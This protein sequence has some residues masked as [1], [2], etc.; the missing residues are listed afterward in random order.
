MEVMKESNNAWKGK[1]CVCI[2]IY[3]YIYIYI[4]PYTKFVEI[5]I[6]P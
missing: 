5:T 2:Y 1:T 4:V 3:I 6:Y